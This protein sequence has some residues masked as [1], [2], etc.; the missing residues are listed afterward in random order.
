MHAVITVV[1]YFALLLVLSL[2]FER[3]SDDFLT[4]RTNSKKFFAGVYRPLI[5]ASAKNFVN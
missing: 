5:L 1:E 2:T 3:I 4:V